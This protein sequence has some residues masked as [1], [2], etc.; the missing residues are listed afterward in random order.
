MTNFN[1]VNTSKIQINWIQVC[2]F[3]FDTILSNGDEIRCTHFAASWFNS[4]SIFCMCRGSN[5]GI[6]SSG[7]PL[8]SC[9]LKSSNSA[10][11]LSSIVE[12]VFMILSAA[13]P[14]I[15]TPVLMKSVQTSEKHDNHIII[16]VNK[17]L[18]NITFAWFNTI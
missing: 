15:F 1:I 4:N 10:R 17:K 6:L 9:F 18:R 16:S 2:Y 3:V 8:M 14:K 12:N 11:N 7:T 13:W 5:T